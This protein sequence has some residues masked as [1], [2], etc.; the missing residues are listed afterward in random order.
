[1]LAL[2]S[3]LLAQPALR[4]RS[5]PSERPNVKP[6]TSTQVMAE[7]LTLRTHVPARTINGELTLDEGIGN[8]GVKPLYNSV[9]WLP[10]EGL[11]PMAA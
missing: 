2:P 1:M 3:L 4:N 9:V 8:R 11:R 5:I 10:V 6:T 7:A